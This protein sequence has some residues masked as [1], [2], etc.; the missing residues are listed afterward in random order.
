MTYLNIISPTYP[1]SNH[2]AS[3]ALKLSFDIRLFNKQ[4]NC[5]INIVFIVVAIYFIMVHK[6]ARKNHPSW[7]W[8]WACASSSSLQPR[9][10]EK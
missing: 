6:A 10:S 1:A 2:I 9:S 3:T 8:L 5:E 4:S 7:H